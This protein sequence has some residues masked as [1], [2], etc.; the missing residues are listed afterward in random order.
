MLDGGLQYYL[1]FWISL[2]I[3]AVI[4][5]AL[6]WRNLCRVYAGYLSFIFQ[7]W[8]LVTFAVA[9]ITLVSVSFYANDPTWD[10]IDSTF[11]A[12]MTYL[13][14]PWAIGVMFRFFRRT[15]PAWHVYLALCAWMFSA[16][17]SYDLYQYLR[18]GFYPES[19]LSN[20]QLS[21]VLYFSAALMWNLT[22]Q[23]GRGVDFA[24]RQH[25]WFSVNQ[26]ETNHK[27][28]FVAA[29]FAF[30]AAAIIL[31]FLWWR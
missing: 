5:V 9:T 7:K 16:S 11:M 15:V 22:Y 10:V 8:K 4:S 6:N 12:V 25:E 3:G 29:P 14:A 13:S 20:L 28:I 1:I 30:L 23:R 18:S 17:W 31:G 21:S 26:T 27:I 2:C 24:F 19:W